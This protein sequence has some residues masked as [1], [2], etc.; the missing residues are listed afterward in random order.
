MFCSRCQR[1][2]IK[3]I[4]VIEKNKLCIVKHTCIYHILHHFWPELLPDGS[5][6]RQPYSKVGNIRAFNGF[7][8]RGGVSQ[9]STM[10][11]FISVCIEP[12]SAH[13]PYFVCEWWQCLCQLTSDGT[14][15]P[16]YGLHSDLYD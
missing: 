5:I 1:I 11:L 2:F 14:A 7:H 6:V 10:P 4:D 16:K 9:V 8:C 15:S 12:V 13:Q 3:H